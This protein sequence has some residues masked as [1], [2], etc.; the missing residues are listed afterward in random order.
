[1]KSARI[2]I[3]V[4]FLFPSDGG[5]RNALSFELKMLRFHFNQ[6]LSKL[7]GIRGFYF[8]FIFDVGQ[9]IEKYIFR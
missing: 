3:G 1:M 7:E 8:I 6:F 9:N 4:I 2:S 5:K